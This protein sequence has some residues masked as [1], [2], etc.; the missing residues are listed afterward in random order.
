MGANT[1]SEK[2]RTEQRN[3]LGTALGWG[4]AGDTR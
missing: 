2:S 3:P 4:L 1:K